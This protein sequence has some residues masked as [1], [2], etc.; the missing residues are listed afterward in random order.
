LKWKIITTTL[1]NTQ[2]K[3][4]QIN[5]ISLSVY[6]GYFFQILLEMLQFLYVWFILCI[7][8]FLFYFLSFD[9]LKIKLYNLL[10]FVFF[11][12]ISVSWLLSWIWKVNLI[13]WVFLFI[14]LLIFFLVSS[15][16]IFNI[17]LI[18]NNALSFVLV[19]FLWSYIS[20]MIW[21]Q[22]LWVNLGKLK[23]FYYVIFYIDFFS[24]SSFNNEFI[25]NQVL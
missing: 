8:Y 18:M 25:E 13:N 4:N 6:F 11:I 20:F 10:W 24:I 21:S 22:V 12:V 15:F 16:S 2:K 7:I 9:L 23:S 19:C 1:S 14:F 17:W 3:N 5:F